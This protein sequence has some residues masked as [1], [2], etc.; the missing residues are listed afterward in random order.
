[1]D[2]KDAC[3]KAVENM[4]NTKMYIQRFEKQ[5]GKTKTYV[6]IKDYDL[7]NIKGTIISNNTTMKNEEK[8]L[9]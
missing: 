1:M 7:K 2:T 6:C 4:N 8:N 9:K 5:T 3:K